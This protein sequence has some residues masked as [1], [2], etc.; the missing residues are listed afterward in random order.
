MVQR[1]TFFCDFSIYIKIAR[2]A[3]FYFLVVTSLLGY[4]SLNTYLFVPQVTSAIQWYWLKPKVHSKSLK[5]RSFGLFCAHLW[6]IP[7]SF[8]LVLWLFFVP[9]LFPLC[10]NWILYFFNTFI[11]FRTL[12]FFSGSFCIRKL[13]HTISAGGVHSYLFPTWRSH[14]LFIRYLFLL[15]KESL[16]KIPMWLIFLQLPLAK[17]SR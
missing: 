14:L 4:P 1:R 6:F 16:Y 2:S 13:H 5:I 9:D 10:S 11:C 3:K 7:L 8:F 12:W 17:V 15:I